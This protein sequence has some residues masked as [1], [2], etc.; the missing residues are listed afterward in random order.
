[1]RAHRAS[2]K[3]PPI[4]TEEYLV[5][6]EEQGLSRDTQAIRPYISEL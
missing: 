4:T 1:M 6:L 5:T 2:L 3:N